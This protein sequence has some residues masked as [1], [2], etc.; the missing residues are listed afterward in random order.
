[1]SK[2]KAFR[3]YFEQ[4]NQT[5]IEVKAGSKAIAVRKAKRAYREHYAEPYVTA[6]EDVVPAITKD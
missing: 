1:M 4:L 6:V 3:V 5:Y 2:T